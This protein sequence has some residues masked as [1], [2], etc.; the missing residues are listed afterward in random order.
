MDLLSMFVML[1]IPGGILFL[2]MTREPPILQEF[3]SLEVSQNLGEH[4]APK[5]G[6]F[7]SWGSPVSLPIVI[8]EGKAAVVENILIFEEYPLVPLRVISS[9]IEPGRSVDVIV[10]KDAQGKVLDIRLAP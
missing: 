5:K 9:W 10:Y 4:T 1:V 6:G 3:E 8:S 2:Y 7:L